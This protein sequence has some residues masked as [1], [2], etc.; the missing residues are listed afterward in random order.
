MPRTTG[1]G[2]GFTVD[3]EYINTEQST[4]AATSP[5]SGNPITIDPTGILGIIPI[6]IHGETYNHPPKMIL[7]LRGTLAM[8]D[9]TNINSVYR[10]PQV[11]DT[12]K[13]INSAIELLDRCNVKHSTPGWYFSTVLIIQ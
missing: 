10:M 7:F 8:Y 6:V 2:Y 13:S 12:D 4:I 9:S 3:S 11:P 1:I 5:A